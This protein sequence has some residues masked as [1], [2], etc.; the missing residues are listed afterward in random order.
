[1]FMHFLAHNMYELLSFE[2]HKPIQFIEVSIV[3]KVLLQL[4]LTFD[5][6]CQLLLPRVYYFKVAWMFIVLNM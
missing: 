3:H 1:M 6:L 4:V 2:T 5:C